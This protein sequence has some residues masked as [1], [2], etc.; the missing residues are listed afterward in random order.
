[1]KKTDFKKYGKMK[2]R[3]KTRKRT[4]KENR[5]LDRF[6][7]FQ[8][9][10]ILSCDAYF[11]FSVSVVFLALKCMHAGPLGFRFVRLNARG[12]I[13]QVPLSKL[14]HSPCLWFVNSV[15]GNLFRNR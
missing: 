15:L 5:K 8:F 2:N 1:M 3:R 9:L 7:A 10:E 14:A 4:T 12:E 6:L 13:L 11:L